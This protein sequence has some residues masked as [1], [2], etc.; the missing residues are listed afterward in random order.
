MGTIEIVL[1]IIGVIFIIGSFFLKE[2]LSRKDIEEIAKLSELELK[3]IVERKMKDAS[4]AIDVVIND[5]VDTSMESVRRSLEKETNQKIMAISEF[6]DTVVD[7]M[8]KTHNEIMFLYS[9]LNDKH[10]ELT[11]LASN[12][13][14]LSSTMKTTE[15]E[16]RMQIEEAALVTSQKE[17]K[18]HEE[19]VEKALEETTVIEENEDNDTPL[20]HSNEE[21]L[22]LHRS[23]KSDV[24]IAKILNRGIGEI[25]LVLGLYREGE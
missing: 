18:K 6:S 14:S 11:G 24:E 25:R 23:G 20:K 16:L 4:D 17:D 21:I 15:N 1:I 7:S 8:N 19:T 22:E 2:V 12:L 5:T 13:Q 3:Q 9:M 10:E